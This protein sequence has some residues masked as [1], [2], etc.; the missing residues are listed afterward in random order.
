MISVGRWLATCQID[1]RDAEILLGESLGISRSKIVTEPEALIS[2]TNESNLNALAK[3]VQSGLPIAYAIGHWEFW[4]LTLKLNDATLIPRPD[5]ELLVELGLDRTPTSASVLELGTG[6]GAIAIALTKTRP[7]IRLTAT[8]LAPSAIVIAKENADHHSVH[9]QFKQTSWFDGLNDVWDVIISNPPYVA[10]ND[11]HLAGLS[12]EPVTALVSGPEGLDD[13]R[14]IIAEAPAHLSQV[15]QLF[16]EHGYDQG[17][18]VRKLFIEAGFQK[19]E[20]HTDLGNNERVT[21]GQ[22]Q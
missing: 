6:S 9:I 11:P 18:A 16:L 15:G 10:M 7:D 4:G 12:H 21:T 5:T 17:S 3:S 22:I 14:H 2:P 13:L 19:I 8:D 1:R 20:T